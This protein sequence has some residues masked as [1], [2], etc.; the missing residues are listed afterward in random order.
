MVGLAISSTQR[1]RCYNAVIFFPN[2][3]VEC[4][5]VVLSEPYHVFYYFSLPYPGH[6]AFGRMYVLVCLATCRSGEFHTYRA[7]RRTEMHRV[8]AIEEEMKHE[9]A[10]AKLQAAM[11]KV[12]VVVCFTAVLNCSRLQAVIENY[13][14]TVVVT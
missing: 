7:H 4:L 2:Y 5:T 8:A 6:D 10:T 14:C 12:T 13:V 11:E 1:I 3:G 9:E